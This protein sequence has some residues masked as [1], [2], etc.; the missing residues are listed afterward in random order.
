MAL[1][2]QRSKSKIP[3]IPG[4]KPSIQN[5]QLLISTGIPSL[6]FMIGLSSYPYVTRCFLFKLLKI[7]WLFVTGGGLP[8]GSILLIGKTKQNSLNSN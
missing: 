4:T 2:T 7:F 5:A 6:D 3:S 1:N 8:I